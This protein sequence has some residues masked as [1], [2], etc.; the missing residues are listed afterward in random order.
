MSTVGICHSPF[1]NKEMKQRNGDRNRITRNNRAIILP[2]DQ[3][4][5]H[6]RLCW[7]KSNLSSNSVE[8]CSTEKSA[9]RKCQANRYTRSCIYG[10]KHQRALRRKIYVLYCVDKWISLCWDPVAH[11]QTSTSL[12]S[13]AAAENGTGLAQPIPGK[14]CCKSFQ[15]LSIPHPLLRD[16]PWWPQFTFDT[17]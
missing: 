16:G 17:W 6:S 14:G 1:I 12:L 11:W 5:A 7:S 4:P 13:P 8:S 3:W 10:T 15:T 9:R 2:Q